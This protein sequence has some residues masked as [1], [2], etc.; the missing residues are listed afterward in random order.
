MSEKRDTNKNISGIERVK[1]KGVH[2]DHKTS[3][4]KQEKESST[5]NKK[6]SNFKTLKEKQNKPFVEKKEKSIVNKKDLNLKT[7]EGKQNESYGDKETA[8]CKQKNLDVDNAKTKT[9]EGEQE[10]KR[11]AKDSKVKKYWRKKFGINKDDLEVG[12]TEQSSI[13]VDTENTSPPK[14]KGNKVK[15]VFIGIAKFPL[16]LTHFVLKSFYLI[17]N[18][19]L[20]LAV[21]LSVCGIMVGIKVMPMY[22]EA[23]KT[24]Y[25]KLSS[26]KDT[27]FQKLE[28]TKVYDKDGNIIGQ[29]DAGDYHY[30]DITDISKY[31]Q[32][33]YISTEDKRFTEH[34]GIDVQS[35]TRAGLS[36]IKN[37]GEITQGGSTITQQVIKNCLLTQEQ[38]FSRKLVEVL[39]APKI[40]QRFS[41]DKIMEFYCNTNYY[42][43]LCYGI[44]TASR[45][46]FGKKSKD[47]SLAE[48]AMLCGVSNSPNNYNPVAS[49]KLAKEKQVQVLGNMLEC[50]YITQEE[51]D[52]ALKY[53]IK[54]KAVD[55]SG[56]KDNY[57]VSYAIHCTALELMKKDNFQF[58]YVFENKKE[59]DKYE[60][61]Y[62][63]KYSEKSSL[64]RSGGY[65]IWTSFDQKLQSKLQRSID[66]GLKGYR[67]K[68]DNGKFALQGSSV[69]IDNETGYVVA[70]VGGRGKNDE[71]NRA[72]LSARQPGS[73]IKPLL[74]YAPAINEGVLNPS[75]VLVD[76]PV[77]AISGDTSSYSPKNS[78]GGYRGSVKVR[79]ALARSIN[80]IAYQIY[81]KVGSETAISYLE[82][83][84]F[85]SLSYA[86]N[87]AEALSL[88]GF[89]NGCKVVDMA[90]GYSTLA[91]GGSFTDRTC[92][93]KVE[94]QGKGI[95][96]E[97]EELSNTKNPVFTEDTAFMMSDIMQG[98]IEEGYGTGRS[99]K[100]SRMIASGKTGTT[101]SNKDAWFCGYTK[102]YT[103]AVWI[104]YDTPR[105]MSGMYGG[106]VP[107]RIWSSY[108][109]G[110]SKN[111]TKADFVMP[112]TISLRR[113]GNGVYSGDDLHFKRNK[114]SYYL[115]TSGTEWFSEQNRT[116][117][118]KYDK[119]SAL[120]DSINKARK[121]L[122]SFLKFNI[123]NAQ[124]AMA[125]D[126][127]YSRVTS[128]IENIDDEYKQRSLREKAADHYSLLSTEVKEKWLQQIKEY[129]AKQE[130]IQRQQA[131]INAETSLH[132]AKRQ[133]RETREAKAEWYITTLSSRMYY[134]DITKKLLKDAKIAVSRLEGYSSYNSYMDRLKAQSKRVRA[135]P[136]P[137][138]DPVIPSDAEDET[139]IDKSEYEED[140]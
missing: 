97:S 98:T 61:E 58:Q 92:L 56:S 70:M 109:K 51:Y 112:E 135:L 140:E 12:D 31:V 36:L 19:L 117:Y 138:K 32:W 34:C 114:R 74:D 2:K 77:Y 103:T 89:T 84:R 121:E 131:K 120:Q 1:N 136:E 87:S 43:N 22:Q 115:R 17:L 27:N 126:G 37:N 39:L 100:D 48:A 64:I 107:A 72:F 95:L 62:S 35:L 85:S 68:Q 104:G 15:R 11:Y 76:K 54:I 3:L 88:G 26:L 29:I 99:I 45:Y 18:V 137:P 113:C 123:E 9:A 73:T 53:K 7:L 50:G 79:E 60:K 111:R 82:K 102:Y 90:R 16:R 28:N 44:D 96:Y 52:K 133:I 139:D 110:I 124:D 67:D 119:E 116:K 134:S 91:M 23:S 106:T 40:E 125:L 105:T 66:N 49:M 108:M 59:Q 75:T 118:N 20:L 5:V 8:S 30:A 83:M 13:K 132:T 55:T 24:A 14:K 69:C 21:A 6:D 10:I 46:Y 65:K 38:T 80:T 71:F 4:I 101:S 122:N 63:Q 25:D 41:K 78:G 129:R 42:G 128:A 86:D 94:F 93:K 130:E 127:M 33:G 47:L 57:M 81:K